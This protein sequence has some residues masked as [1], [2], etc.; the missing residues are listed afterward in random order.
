MSH[1]VLLRDIWHRVGSS[2]LVVQQ[3]NEQMDRQTGRHMDRW[4]DGQQGFFIL[5]RSLL[6]LMSPLSRA[7][8]SPSCLLVLHSDPSGL[9]SPLPKPLGVCC[10]W[11][12]MSWLSTPNTCHHHPP[13]K[14]LPSLS[15]HLTCR[16]VQKKYASHKWLNQAT[17]PILSFLE[18]QAKIGIITSY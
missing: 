2:L 9:H 17:E 1:L 7:E 3:M 5:D 10:L 4:R 12:K 6:R 11:L 8:D 14:S 16:S 13:K 18:K 15:P